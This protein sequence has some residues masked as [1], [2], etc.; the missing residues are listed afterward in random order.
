MIAAIDDLRLGCRSVVELCFGLRTFIVFSQWCRSKSC[1]SF[2]L[3]RHLTGD[4]PNS[5][6]GVTE[7][8]PFPSCHCP[9]SSLLSIFNI[10]HLTF[11]SPWPETLSLNS[12]I[13]GMHNFTSTPCIQILKVPY[14]LMSLHLTLSTGIRPVDD[15][16]SDWHF[17]SVT[18]SP[19]FAS[20]DSLRS[21]PGTCR[22]VYRNEL[23]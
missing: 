21:L 11:S 17:V 6:T 23:S 7:E 9:S 3:F 16:V 18:P 8:T 20:L 10:S 19:T 14:L 12:I 4:F 1:C 13:A 15:I 2:Y 22:R 5:T